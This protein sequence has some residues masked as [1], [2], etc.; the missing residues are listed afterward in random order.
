MQA[1]RQDFYDTCSKLEQFHQKLHM[2]T[3][4]ILKEATGIFVSIVELV[5]T[6]VISVM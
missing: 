2:I 6:P 1:C 5:I 4:H 3:E